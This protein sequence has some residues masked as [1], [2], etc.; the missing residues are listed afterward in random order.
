M[1]NERKQTVCF[2]VLIFELKDLISKDD[3]PL[4][5]VSSSIPR[6]Q[7]ILKEIVKQNGR[8]VLICG[9]IAYNMEELKDSEE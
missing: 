2:V 5:G 9:Q 6:L 1:K 8:F 3:P 4:Q 7:L